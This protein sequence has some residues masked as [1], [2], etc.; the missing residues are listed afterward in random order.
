M[1]HTKEA[2]GEATIS[3]TIKKLI[4]LL[5]IQR[6]TWN[7]NVD[8]NSWSQTLLDIQPLIWGLSLFETTTNT[9]F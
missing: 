5:E 2:R 4:S 3:F 6:V 1:S 8:L 9:A 7:K